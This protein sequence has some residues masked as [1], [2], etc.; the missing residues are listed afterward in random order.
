MKQLLQWLFRQSPSR[1]I[2]RD[3]LRILL[4]SDRTECSPDMLAQIKEEIITVLSKYMRID[5]SS[6]E[7]QISQSKSSNQKTVPPSLYAYIPIL[8]IHK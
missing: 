2:A 6:T 1:N 8:D 4:I 7:I 3:R 5:E